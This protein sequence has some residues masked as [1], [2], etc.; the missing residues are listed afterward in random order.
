MLVHHGYLKV[1]NE[2]KLSL[3]FLWLVGGGPWGVVVMGVACCDVG[4]P[5]S[6]QSTSAFQSSPARMWG[7]YNSLVPC[8]SSLGVSALPSAGW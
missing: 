7:A 3:S 1:E 6:L 4:I 5:G 2:P 8:G